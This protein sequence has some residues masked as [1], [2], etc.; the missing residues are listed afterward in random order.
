MLSRDDRAAIRAAMLA[1]AAA[2]EQCVTVEYD[3]ERL[4]RAVEQL[5]RL[6][7]TEAAWGVA[8]ALAL[9]RPAP[10]LPEMPVLVALAA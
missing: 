7:G 1:V 8:E 4:T 5:A 6:I 2:L 9:L 3:V 10:A